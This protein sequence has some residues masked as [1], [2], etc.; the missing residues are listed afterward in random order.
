[1]ALF[2]IQLNLHHY[3]DCIW[4]MGED[5]WRKLDLRGTGNKIIWK[6]GSEIRRGGE[7]GC[8]RAVS[9]GT[10]NNSPAKPQEV[11]GKA[12]TDKGRWFLLCYGSRAE[13]CQSATGIHLATTFSTRGDGVGADFAGVVAI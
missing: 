10:G 13:C 11:Q 8:R 9:G 12:I 1:M 7:N 6:T 5:W 3:M 4:G 2:I